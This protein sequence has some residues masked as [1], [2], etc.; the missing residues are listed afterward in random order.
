MGLRIGAAVLLTLLAA[1]G[2]DRTDRAVTG[3]A[4]GAGTGGLGALILD[5]DV[6]TGLVTGA[7]VG[8]ATGGLTTSDDFDLGEPIYRRRY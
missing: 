3:A 7:I 2:T 4:I 1:C 6:G 5:G 8:A